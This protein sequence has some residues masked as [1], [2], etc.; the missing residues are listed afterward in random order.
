MV[1]SFTGMVAFHFRVNPFS[2]GITSS[3]VQTQWGLYFNNLLK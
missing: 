3:A 2:V 1:L